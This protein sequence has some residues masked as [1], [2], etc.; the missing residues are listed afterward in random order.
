MKHSD[1]NE[2]EIEAIFDEIPAQ[3]SKHEKKFKLSDIKPSA[4][5][6][7]YKQPFYWLDDAMIVNNCYNSTEPN[8]GL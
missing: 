1:G 3:L 7:E 8:I 2:L 4:R 5:M 6:R